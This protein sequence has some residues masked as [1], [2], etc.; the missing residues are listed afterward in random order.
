MIFGLAVAEIDVSSWKRG[1]AGE[2]GGDTTSLHSSSLE[3]A[4]L[5]HNTV[6]QAV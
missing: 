6:L 2:G 5:A 4:T 1:V 3:G